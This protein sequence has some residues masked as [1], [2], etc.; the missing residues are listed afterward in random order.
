M[1]QQEQFTRYSGLIARQSDSDRIAG[2]L[3][4]QEYLRWRESPSKAATAA[5][6][7]DHKA[8]MYIL[9]N[10]GTRAYN[11]Y[12]ASFQPR[13][14]R[15]ALPRLQIFPDCRELRR[16][17]PLCIYA[18]KSQVSDKPAEDVR[19]FNG[20]DPYDAVR[21]LIMGVDR[22]LGTLKDQGES[23]RRENHLIENLQKTGN[24]MAYYR[25]M[26][27]LERK[28]REIVPISRYRR[29]YV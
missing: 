26:E 28:P 27:Q 3:L 17:I 13:Q 29:Q 22:Y 11:E 4:L 10:D 21:Y 6:E 24:W 9:R 18:K 19:E 16:C 1:T 12:L 15:A 7:Y 8:A 14:E 20:D 25:G 5:K 23:R 2:K